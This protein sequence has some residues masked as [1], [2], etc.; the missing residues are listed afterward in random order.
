MGRK[1]RARRLVKAVDTN[2][3]VRVLMRD[4][5][6]QTEAAER[7][8]KAG[9][10]IPL[11]VLLETGW[12]L[13]SRYGLSRVNIADALSTLIDLPGVV[14]P[15]ADAV[16][17]ALGRFAEKGDLGDLLHLAAS[18]GATAFQTFDRRFAKAVGDTS[19]LAVETLG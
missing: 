4:T 7:A 5:P 3:L 16:R 18:A 17:W 11:T 6:A 10:M 15:E 2:I 14:V 8:L 19:P 1:R 9:A 12:V 13:S